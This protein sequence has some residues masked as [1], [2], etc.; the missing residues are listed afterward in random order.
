VDRID[1][2]DAGFLYLETRET[3]THV[4]GLNLLAFPERVTQR[5]FIARR[6]DSCRST[7]ELEEMV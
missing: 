2:G 5:N 6:G 3:P 1:P 7:T 4:A